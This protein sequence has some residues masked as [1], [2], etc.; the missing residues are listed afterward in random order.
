MDRNKKGLIQFLNMTDQ[1]ERILWCP[2]CM[3]KHARDL[4][5]HAEAEGDSELKE[6]A[7]KAF[8]IS[9]NMLGVKDKKLY[10]DIRDLE[11]HSEDLLTALRTERK[12]LTLEKCTTCEN[13]E[14]TVERIKERAKT[15]NR[16]TDKIS[17]SIQD[18]EIL[19]A[20]E[21]IIQPLVGSF[22]GKGVETV[23]T[24][25]ITGTTFGVSNKTLANLGIGIAIDA[26]ALLRP[27]T[28]R[29]A[30]LPLVV[31]GSF[32]IA[33]EVVNIAAGFIPG[34]P[35]TTPAPAP[36]T[37]VPTAVSVGVSQFSNGKHIFVD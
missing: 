6:I 10:S 36:A 28:F 2:D 7:Q 37:Y 17:N 24:K 23:T 15:L 33:N 29:R 30:E 19:M 21:T 14:E 4:L 32:L 1:I 27:G 11:H 9:S 34:I 31:A 16:A 13:L 18:K 35:A 20:K 25:F 22:I 5:H 8:N 12:K 26:I 3:T